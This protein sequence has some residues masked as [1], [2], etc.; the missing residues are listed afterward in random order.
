MYMTPREFLETCFSPDSMP[1]EI[2]VRNWIKRGELNGRK[3]GGVYYVIVD[4]IN[5]PSETIEEDIEPNFARYI[6]G[7]KSNA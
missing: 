3:L 4:D 1:T 5:K 2:T 6:N 7:G